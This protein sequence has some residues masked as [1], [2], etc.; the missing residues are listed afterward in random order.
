M[1][2][3]CCSVVPVVHRGSD[4]RFAQELLHERL[5]VALVTG[6]QELDRDAAFQR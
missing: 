1:N 2:G 3:C 6:E 5:L 4:A